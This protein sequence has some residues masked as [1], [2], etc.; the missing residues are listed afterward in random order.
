MRL[1]DEHVDHHRGPERPA[2]AALARRSLR[3]A[4]PRATRAAASCSS[5]PQRSRVDCRDA[6]C[7]ASSAALVVQGGTAPNATRPSC[8]VAD[9]ATR[10]RRRA[11]RRLDRPSGQ[12]RGGEGQHGPARAPTAAGGRGRARDDRAGGSVEARRVRIETHAAR[13]YGAAPAT[14]SAAPPAR[15]APSEAA[16]RHR[17]VEPAARPQ[18]TSW[19]SAHAAAAVRDGTPSF[20][21]M[22]A[23][24]RCTVC[25]ESSS[26]AAISASVSPRATRR[27]TSRSRAVRRGAR[28]AGPA[29]SPAD[30]PPVRR[31]RRGSAASRARRR[32]R[33]RARGS[34][35][36]PR[37]PRSSRSGCARRRPCRARTGSPGRRVGAARASARGRRRGGRS[38]RSR[39]R[40]AATRGRPSARPIAAGTRRTRRVPRPSRRAGTCPRARASRAPSAAPRPRASPRAP[41]AGRGRRHA[42]RCRR[43]RVARRAADAAPRTATRPRRPMR[44]RTARWACAGRRVDEGLE[45]HE[46]LLERPRRGSPPSIRHPGAR[47]VVADHGAVRGEPFDEPPEA[48]VAPVEL[49]MARPPPADDERRSLPD[50]RP[51]QCTPRRAPRSGS[52]DPRAPCPESRKPSRAGL[53]PRA[54]PRS[55]ACDVVMRRSREHSAGARR[56]TPPRPGRRAGSARARPAAAARSSPAVD[57]GDGAQEPRRRAAPRSRQ[58]ML[59]RHPGEPGELGDGHGPELEEHAIV[60]ALAAEGDGCA[61][62]DDGATRRRLLGDGDRGHG[63]PSTCRPRRERWSTSTIPRRGPPGHREFGPPRH[64]RFGPSCPGRG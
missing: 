58:G 43:A 41:G 33:R 64:G 34:G 25:G 30:R 56:R 54:S 31:R 52:P 28:L 1:D 14:V 29:G 39:T 9:V 23:T 17:S 63:L 32:R 12:R 47:P 61:V 21:R 62:L 44:R 38:N 11:A 15:D 4:G 20:V 55:T 50:G 19:R 35:R 57:R 5:E 7:T 37:G 10:P 3:V 24:C 18:M 8:T 27:S 48:R 40:R 42:R 45:V 22:F 51:R 13:S 49:E 26:R 16:L 6:R 36:R 53:R 60:A 2:E 46:L 59:L